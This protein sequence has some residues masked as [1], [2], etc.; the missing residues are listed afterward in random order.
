MQQNSIHNTAPTENAQAQNPF[1]MSGDN[2]TTLVHLNGPPD[3]AAVLEALAFLDDFT[4]ALAD[5]EAS[6]HC[7]GTP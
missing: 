3:D 2:F 5:F 6:E 1:P 4:I 7:T